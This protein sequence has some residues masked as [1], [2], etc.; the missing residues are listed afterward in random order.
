MNAAKDLCNMCIGLGKRDNS[1]M[2]L[3]SGWKACPGRRKQINVVSKVQIM[4][5]SAEKLPSR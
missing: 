3:K 5:G 1:P 4:L 2:C